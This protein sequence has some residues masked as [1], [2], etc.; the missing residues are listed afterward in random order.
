VRHTAEGAGFEHIATGLKEGLM[1]RADDI[2][3]R[4]DEDLGA[5]LATAV[6]AID[7]EFVGVGGGP[8]GAVEDEAA[9]GEVLQEEAG[10]GVRKI[11][12]PNL[13][14]GHKPGDARPTFTAGS[15]F[16]PLMRIYG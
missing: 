15:T 10:H 1:N 6:I 9:F 11:D 7:G 14:P 8:H 4:S 3:A 2:R 12:S 5:V 16:H 13:R